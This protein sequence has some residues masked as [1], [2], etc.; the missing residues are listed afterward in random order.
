MRRGYFLKNPIAFVCVMVSV[1][2]L[3]VI[4]ISF[5]RLPVPEASLGN[6][7][8]KPYKNANSRKVLKDEGI[9]KLGDMM[10]EMSPEELAF[11]VFI[12]SEKAFERDLRLQVN[13]SSLTEKRTNTYAVV[14]PLL[15]F[16]AIPRAL[17]S[18]MV[19]SSKEIVYDSLSGFTLYTS[20]DVDGMLEVN[21]VRSERVDRRRGQI[22]VHIMDGVIV[23]AEFKQSLQPAENEED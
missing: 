21:R 7:V 2:C 13:D 15:G 3:F 5:L 19:S 11:T 1:C 16:S 22:I 14:S 20:K 6:R 10:I 12:P 17:F 8:I 18:D 9:G 23:D 4:M